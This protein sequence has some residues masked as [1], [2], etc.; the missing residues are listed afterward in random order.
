MEQLN[1]G[2]LPIASKIVFSQKYARGW[3]ARR[4]VSAL[5]QSAQKDM[6]DIRDLCLQVTE[7]NKGLH[8]QLVKRGEQDVERLQIMVSV[9]IYL[10]IY[11]L[12]FLYTNIYNNRV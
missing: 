5:W 8:H 10:F 3:L 12:G 2:L 6:F 9:L 1:A 11:L 4:R 7:L